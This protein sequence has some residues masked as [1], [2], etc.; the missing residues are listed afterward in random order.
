MTKKQ[1]ELECDVTLGMLS[2]ERT[3]VIRTEGGIKIT[4]LA[5]KAAVHTE[6]EVR[7]DR[8]V[9]G[10]V[11]VNLVEVLENGLL[12]ELPPPGSIRGNRIVVGRDRVR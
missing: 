4:A 2:S 7:Q 9:R 11:V 8:P 6:E 3:I 1:M 12:V 10:T 5:T